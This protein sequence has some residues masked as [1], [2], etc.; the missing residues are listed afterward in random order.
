M[1][2]PLWTSC[3]S[4][5]LVGPLLDD[6]LLLQWDAKAGGEVLDR[7]DKT[8]RL[9][10]SQKFDRIA[11]GTTPVTVVVAIPFAN[12]ERGGPLLME[13]AAGFVTSPGPLQIDP[14]RDDLDQIDPLPQRLQ[15]LLSK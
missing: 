11:M 12:G 10:L 2:S 1:Q 14:R 5:P 15:T 4:S 8:H 9:V 13:G 3:S 7:L 6:L